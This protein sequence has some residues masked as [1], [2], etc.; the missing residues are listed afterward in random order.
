M[1]QLSDAQRLG[2]IDET[3]QGLA[4]R[5]GAFDPAA[6]AWIAPQLLEGYALGMP[7]T[8]LTARLREDGR[9]LDAIRRAPGPEF[10]K[11]LRA[12]VALPDRV[13]GNLQMQVLAVETGAEIVLLRG[14][15]PCDASEAFYWRRLLPNAPTPPYAGCDR[16]HCACRYSRAPPGPIPPRPGA[17]IA[18][19]RPTEH[20]PAKPRRGC[21][22]TVGVA[23]AWLFGLYLV[24]LTALSF[25][26]LL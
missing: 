5:T 7:A 6:I 2:I 17:A 1:L 16:L 19:Q 18:E 8:A 23:L 14:K 21:L 24:M 4:V 11:V 25:L 10:T 13:L 15:E 12:I 9:C 3:L 20:G 22:G 26:G